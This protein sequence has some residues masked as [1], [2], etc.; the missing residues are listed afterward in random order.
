MIAM[1]TTIALSYFM[2]DDAEQAI[3]DTIEEELCIAN[4]NQIFNQIKP[5]APFVN[6]I[7]SS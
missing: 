1:M 3:R 5:F 6:S 7:T 2:N 4:D